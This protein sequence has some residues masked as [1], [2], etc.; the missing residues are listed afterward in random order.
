[1][2]PL[3]EV[4]RAFEE[5]HPSVD[6]QIEGHG[7][8]Q[9]IRQ[10]TEL[11]HDAD[12]LMVADYSLVPVMMYTTTIPDTNEPFSSWCIRFATN[13]M[14]LAYTNHSRY[15]SEINISNWCSILARPNVRF[16]F[17]NPMVDALGY[18]T[19]MTI[20]LAESLPENQQ[21]FKSLITDN[22]DPPISSIPEG[23][24]YVITVP[25]VQQP[26]SDQ[27]TLRASSIH[28]IPLLE[29][30]NVDYCF[31]YLSN[32][33]QCGFAFIEFTDEINLGNPGYDQLYQ[34]VNV[35]F[36]HQRFST[37]N[38]DREGRTINYGLTIPKNALHPELSA[39]FVRFILDGEGRNIFESSY[40]PVFSPAFIDNS[41]NLPAILQPLVQEAD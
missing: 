39:E 35:K 9:V 14:V 22:F 25:E 33:K 37:T 11:G 20:Q 10:V 12:L 24:D 5:E 28:L 6:L 38:L 3:G 41:S 30:G 18:R 27:V 19:L 29:T 4:E 23:D 2:F 16:G 7:S 32:A 21:A 36:E 13:R 40:H 26:K 31:L 8:I 1:M 34:H 15:A 17:P